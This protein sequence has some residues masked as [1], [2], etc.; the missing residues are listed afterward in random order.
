MDKEQARFILSS[1]RP[2]GNEIQDQDFTEALALAATNREL[3]EW[4][5]RER[6]MDEVFTSAL[7][8]IQLPD[9][10]RD[11]IIGCLEGERNDYPSA[12]QQEDAAMIGALA[13]VKI[14][15]SLRGNILSAMEQ[16]AP[17]SAT[18]ATTPT[19]DT[20]VPFWKRLGLPLA[21]A[22]GIALAL[23][24]TRPQTNNSLATL[25]VPIEAVPAS[26]IQTYE[27]PSFSLDVKQDHPEQL[28]EVLK[29]RALPC[30][31]CLPPGLKGMKS[32]GCRELEINGKHGSLICFNTTNHGVVHLII[33][34]RDDVDGSC[35]NKLDDPCLI[36]KGN[37][38][39]ARWQND[40]NVF[41]LVGKAKV[42]E[43]AQLF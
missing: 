8:S 32:V 34:R 20:V 35:K 18:I 27:S 7:T 26:F 40:E 17:R 39:V 12:D 33:F 16:S 37:W 31:C 13:S 24:I 41:F 23:V 42:D 43:L 5:A 29:S 4:L 30:P 11:D 14:P 36:D 10:L 38:S 2:D 22:A 9:S 25:P 1:Y 15:D 3:G 6:A 28:V 21:A 19:N